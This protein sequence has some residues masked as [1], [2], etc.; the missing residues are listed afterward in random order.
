MDL[1]GN[2]SFD[3]DLPS[4]TAGV[5]ADSQISLTTQDAQTIGAAFD[6]ASASFATAM[7]AAVTPVYGAD[8]AGNTQLGGYTLSVDNAVSGLS[9]DGLAIT[10][11]KVGNDVVGSTANG[12]VFRISVNASGTVTLTQYAEID[13]LPESLNTSNDNANIALADGKVSLSATATVTDGDNDQATTQ[14]RVDLGGNISFDDDLPSVGPNVS[15]QLDDDALSGG[16]PGGI[17]DDANAVNVSGTLAHSFG[18]DGAGSIEWLTTG[19]PAGFTYVSSGDDLLIQQGGTTVVTVTLNTATGAYSVTQNAVINHPLGLDENN[20]S[21]DLAYR[22]IDGDNDT[23]T[24]KLTINVDDDTPQAFPDS[25]SVTEAAGKNIN[26]AFVLDSSGSIS[27]SEFAT[28]MAAVKSAG[29]ALF[30]GNDGD[31]KVTIVAFSSDSVSYPAV[32]TLAAFNA[33]VDNIAANRPFNGQTDFTDAIQETML[34]YTPIAGSSN[35]VFFIS[36]GNPNQQTGTGGNSLTDTTASDWNNFVDSNAINVTTIGVGNGIDEDRLQDVDLDGS[37]SPIVVSGFNA[38]VAALLD[39]VSPPVVPIEGNVLSNDASGAD[40]PLSFV[41]WSA[42]NAAAIADLSQYGTLVLDANGHYKFTLNNDAA[43]TQALDDGDTVVKVLHYTAQDADGDPTSSTLTITINGS[44][45]SPIARGDSNWAQED[46]SNASGNVLQNQAHN[47]APDNALRADVAD[48]DVDDSLTVTGVTGGNAYGTLT[49]GANGDYTYA[50]NNNNPTVQALNDGD[51]LTEVYT[52]TVTDGDVSRT[53]SLTIT[54]FG[55]DENALVVGENVSDTSDQTVDHRVDT[56]RY[57]PDGAI[58]GSSGNDVLIGDVGGGKG[59]VINPA[60][61]YNIALILDSSGS[62]T[63][64]PDGPGGYSSRL[65]LLKDSVRSYLD[66]LDSHTG[67]I[68]IALISFATGSSLMLSGTLAEVQAQLDAPGNPLNALSANG[69]TNYESALQTTN[70]WFAGVEGNGYENVAYFL[71]D[72]NPTSRIG[73][74]STGNSV[75]Y[76]D[77]VNALDDFNTLS[78]RAEVHAIGIG[79]GINENILRYFDDTAQLAGNVTTSVGGSN[80]TAPVGEPQI[81]LTPDELNAALDPGSTTPGS[82]SPLGNDHLIGGAGDDL[83][84]G[85][86]LNTSL[87]AGIE[88]VPPGYQALVDHLQAGNGGVA[89]TQAQIVEFITTHA[90]Q[91]GAS[92]PNSGGNDTLEGGAG[93]DVLFGQGGNDRLIGGAGDDLLV[94]GG[95]NDTFVWQAGETGNDTVQDFHRVAGDND[96]LDLSQLLSGLDLGS[97]GSNDAIATFLTSPANSYL[98]VN[99]VGT[100]SLTVD[101]GTGSQSI[102]LVGVDLAGAYGGS[103]EFDIVSGMLDDGSLKVV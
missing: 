18:A 99:T 98:S 69:S 35:Q 55:G 52:Y 46:V 101:V 2:I 93:N 44:N 102:Q 84:F 23:A 94:G 65:A 11:A 28:M 82:L 49:L 22:V 81:V 59:P 3:D 34:A 50:L 61:D 100:N 88:S 73:N 31:V 45:D 24:G 26:A 17:G 66:K 103:S 53:A 38:L 91:M 64:D 27:N 14:V 74:T 13:H 36:D 12:E 51:T 39:A 92:V 1:G 29:Q 78:A 10:L 97:M 21:F 95:G 72:G 77:V 25:G 33:L 56:S 76:L 87:I 19:N 48:T 30:N 85:D 6:T 41:G 63:S 47:G 5:V 7:L 79:S 57:G 32:T 70:S 90:E 43:A 20:V 9:S 71:T 54:I 75:D 58:E 89:P 67:Q 8:G 37:G 62:M 16:I 60:K 40:A 4:V 42:G 68:N 96:V 86:A 15:V 80:V 83:I